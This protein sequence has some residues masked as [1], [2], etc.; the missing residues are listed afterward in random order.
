MNK[1]AIQTGVC[2]GTADDSTAYQRKS[3][4][5]SP[6]SVAETPTVLLRTVE[7]PIAF[8]VL[9]VGTELRAEPTAVRGIAE[10]SDTGAPALRGRRQALQFEPMVRSRS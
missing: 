8:F 10:R 2:A 5:W 4:P 9:N 7:R 3:S 1:P 6:Q